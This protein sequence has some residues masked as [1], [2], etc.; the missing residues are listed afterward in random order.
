MRDHGVRGVGD[1]ANPLPHG[2]HAEVALLD[3]ELQADTTNLCGVSRL[4][5]AAAGGAHPCRIHAHVAAIADG[6]TVYRDDG[7][8][9]KHGFETVDSRAGPEAV[10]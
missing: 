5:T 8:E 10:H 4:L 3:F 6:V 7:S 1:F 2:A 9:A